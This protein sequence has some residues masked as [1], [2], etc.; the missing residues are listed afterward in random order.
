[1]HVVADRP[2]R[3]AC[4]DR[5]AA[6]SFMNFLLMILAC[7]DSNVWTAVQNLIGLVSVHMFLWVEQ[8]SI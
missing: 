1:M 3:C 7:H 6:L 5:H 4:N 2:A 8:C